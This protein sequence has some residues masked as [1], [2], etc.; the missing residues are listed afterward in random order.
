MCP[1]FFKKKSIYNVL[2]SE[3]MFFSILH[4]EMKKKNGQILRRR[5]YDLSEILKSNTCN[6]SDF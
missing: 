3:V 1:I 6:M 2:E 5:N 4:F